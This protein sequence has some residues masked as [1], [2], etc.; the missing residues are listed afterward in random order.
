[1]TTQTTA[2]DEYDATPTGQ[3][4][5]W[6]SELEYAKTQF[7][8]FQKDGNEVD[9]T[10]KDKRKG[11][12]V[13]K[14]RL[15]LFHANVTTL[16]S[17]LYGRVPQVDV[18]RRWADPNDDVARV[19]SEMVERML[20]IDIEVAGET[21][22]NN[23]R[24]ALSDRLLPGLACG[25]VRYCCTMKDEE[26]PATVDDTG[27]VK[28]PGYTQTTKDDEWVENLY[29]PWR[30]VLWSPARFW[31]EVRWMA[32]R[33]YMG[34]KD[35]AERFGKDIAK[36][37][38]YNAKSP[39]DTNKSDNKEIWSKAEVWEIWDKDSKNVIWF[40][41]G[42]D[43]I[44]DLKP[45]VLELEGFWPMPIPMTSNVTTTE[46]MPIADYV[47]A[48]DLYKEIDKLQERIQALTVAAKVT[49]V[50]D[51]A[52]AKDLGQILK[53]GTEN[54][55]IPVDNWAMF[56]EKGGIKGCMDFLPLE[57]VVNAIET[58]SGE[59]QKRI[60]QLYQI[61]GMSDIM[62]GAA[63]P[64]ASATQDNLKAKFSSV[65]VQALQDE[66]ARFATDL[67]KLKFEIIAK[68]FDPQTIVKAS[69]ILF[70]PDAQ[71]ADQA[72]QLIK[73]PEVSK[74]RI[75]IRSESL[76]MVDYAQIRQE[77][78]EYINALGLFMQSAAPIAEKF[79][80]AAPVLLELLKW[81]M[82]GFK[83]SNQIEGVIDQA[84]DAI[85]QA[86]TTS[87]AN[88][89]PPP[90][91][92]KSQAIQAQ[93]QA[94]Q[95]KIQAETQQS[96]ADFQQ[97]MQ[98]QNQEH[99]QEMQKLNQLNQ[100]KLSEMVANLKVEMLKINAGSDA[101]LQ[102]EAAKKEHTELKD[103]QKEARTGSPNA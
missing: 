23:M 34:R 37:I 89:Q 27:L 28:V 74:W 22:S 7:K 55:L 78:T 16:T 79:P 38:P 10:Y 35:V 80:E 15:N 52:S 12:Y 77:R 57:E 64:R 62:R 63:D 71:Y 50:Y 6:N 92:P 47:I 85:K 14:T 1:M 96:Q 20:N 58:L 103:A 99:F 102:L 73:N 26:V 84:I 51:K 69:N 2:A 81:G 94:D 9:L 60:E 18:N 100:Q 95:G 11:E 45:D 46:F 86:Q 75:Q 68:H 48:Q 42:Y 65:R 61:T 19:A 24:A 3:A 25:R 4:A 44:L 83:G 59:Q 98:I 49:G 91:D 8:Q 67:Q 29:V 17:M 101:D 33:S 72:I 76:A 90:P 87:A 39:L 70:T 13:Q 82:A 93:A 32:F 31:A 21:Y 56:S 36:A 88:P 53:P 97:K 54:K 40:T 5:R 30:D 66:F 43:K 41:F